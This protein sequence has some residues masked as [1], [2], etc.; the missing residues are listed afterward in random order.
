MAAGCQE[1]SSPGSVTALHVERA[2]D[3]AQVARGKAL[4]AQHCAH[5]HGDNAQGDPDWRQRHPDGTFPPPPLDGSG[6]AWHH[7]R[8]WL[9]EVIVSG[10]EPQGRMP[11]WGGKLNDQEIDDII[12][13]FQ[14]LWPD[15]VYATWREMEQRN[16]TAN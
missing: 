8:D 1:S 7:S 13:W 6:H 14:S 4:F 15:E 11:A 16:R 12:A 9:N 2:I 5:C 10:T 3:T